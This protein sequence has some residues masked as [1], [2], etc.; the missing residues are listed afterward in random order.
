MF[1]E[2]YDLTCCFQVSIDTSFDP[3]A[4]GSLFELTI[5]TTTDAMPTDAPTLSPRISN[6]GSCDSARPLLPGDEIFGSTSS[7]TVSNSRNVCVDDNMS[8]GAW[9]SV[10]GTGTEL[11]TFTCRGSFFSFDTVITVYEGSSCSD[12]TCVGRDDNACGIQSIFAWNSQLGAQYF[13]VVS[14]GSADDSGDYQLNVLAGQN[15]T[16][17]PTRSPSAVPENDLCD[18]AMSLAMLDLEDGGPV[19]IPGSTK[20]ASF[21]DAPLCGTGNTG[22]GT[23][24]TMMGD[25]SIMTVDTCEANFD[26]KLSIYAGSSCA[27][28]TCVEGNDDSCA[29]GS[30]VTFPTLQGENYWFLVHGFGV[31]VG[32]YT[33][34]INSSN[35]SDLTA[36]PTFAPS[37]PRTAMPSINRTDVAPPPPDSPNTLLPTSTPNS[38]GTTSAC[39]K[40]LTF[41]AAVCCLLLCWHLVV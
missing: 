39:S 8:A 6:N 30:S 23:W 5:A 17:S 27:A 4:G 37:N 33:L 18:S 14:G 21:D 25:G 10:Q 15:F 29:R 40:S 28:L 7:F 24:Y 32:D 11:R 34:S 41:L 31:D 16:E 12:L 20:A 22:P 13:I 3:D 1:L 36:S 38:T 35:T 9:F 2:I 26:T 19:K